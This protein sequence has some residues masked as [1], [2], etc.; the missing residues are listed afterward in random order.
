MTT[1]LVDLVPATRITLGSN[2]D[3][4]LL[5]MKNLG[6]VYQQSAKFDL[7]ANF[8][9]LYNVRLLTKFGS[10]PTASNVMKLWVGFSTSATAA[11][12]NV[13]S[14]TGSD[15]AYTGY[16]GGT[17][18]VSLLQLD[19]VGQM[20]LDANAGPQDGYVGQ[21]VPKARYCYMV[22]GNL[23]GQTT[24]NVD[25]DHQVQI[26]PVDPRIEAGT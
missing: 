20:I 12:D 23:S 19:F 6:A 16:S 15:A 25:A 22:W 18:V 3:T 17:A 21:F 10:A 4:A 13:G 8:H 7:G 2:T 24:T 26:D 14:C 1:Q 9:S 11:T 5:T